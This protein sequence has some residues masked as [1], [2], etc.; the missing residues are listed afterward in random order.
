MVEKITWE[1][2]VEGLV[3][4]TRAGQGA[5]AV[6]AWGRACGGVRDS[7]AGKGRQGPQWPRELRRR[8]GAAHTEGEASGGG[9]RVGVCAEAGKSPEW[10]AGRRKDG[11][12]SKTRKKGP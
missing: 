6:S 10:E 2:L 11:N 7:R 9:R 5:E 3:H 12:S 8:R 4:N 1:H